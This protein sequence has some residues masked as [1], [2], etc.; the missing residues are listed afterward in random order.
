MPAIA[1]NRAP[2]MH[3]GRA[4]AA[5]D[6]DEGVGVA[7]EH[8]RRHVERTQRLAATPR[9]HDRGELT[10]DAARAEAAIEGVAHALG[11]TRRGSY[12]L[13]LV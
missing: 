11:R 2:G 13:G 5:T 7:V 10:G 12:S 1:T 8:Q 4:L 9:G 6:V 3:C